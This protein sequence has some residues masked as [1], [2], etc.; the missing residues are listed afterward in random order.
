MA[1]SRS[2]S[3]T[4]LGLAKAKRATGLGIITEVMSDRDVDLVADYADILQ[5]GSRNMENYALL[6]AAARVY[7]R[8]GFESATLDEVAE[9]A[10][11]TKGAV[12]DHFGSKEKLLFALL[13]EYLSVQIAEQIA[14]FDPAAETAAALKRQVERA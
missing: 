3:F 11:F 5:I 1:S 12:Y 7:A 2:A 10:G 14:L 4:A 13:D 6:E 8:R 9:E